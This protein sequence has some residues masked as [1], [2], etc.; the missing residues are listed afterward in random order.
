MG[1]KQAENPYE[2]VSTKRNTADIKDC[3]TFNI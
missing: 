2:E 1:S 3:V